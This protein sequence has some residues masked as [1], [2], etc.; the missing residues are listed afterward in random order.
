VPG[1]RYRG[2]QAGAAATARP[3]VPVGAIFPLNTVKLRPDGPT[4]ADAAGLPILPALI[5]CDEIRA[6]SIDRA[7]RFTVQN[8]QAGYIHPATHFASADEDRN[9]PPIG[10]RVRLKTSYDISHFNRTA[11]IVLIAMKT[12]GM[13]VADNGSNW[14]FQGEGGSAA[15]C[16]N[17][18]ELDALKNVP[19]SAFEVVKTGPILRS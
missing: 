2:T 16:W 17:D 9:L 7:L 6:G 5:R 10:L 3:S 11:T 18:R 19:G 8:P 15:A 1:L 4:S 13:F 14:F 12:Y